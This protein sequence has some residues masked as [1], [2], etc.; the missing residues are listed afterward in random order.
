[1]HCFPKNLKDSVPGVPDVNPVQLFKSSLG[2]A[3]QHLEAPWRVPGG[4]LEVPEG[5]W[6]VPGGSLERPWKAPGS[7]NALFSKES[8]GF[9]SRGT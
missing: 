6:G 7:P 3:F 8:K 1:M 5:P 9:G 2:L 4:S